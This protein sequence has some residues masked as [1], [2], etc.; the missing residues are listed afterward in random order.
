MW[1]SG[2]GLGLGVGRRG[3][4]LVRIRKMGFGG[5][6]GGG[7]GTGGGLSGWFVV[8]VMVDLGVMIVVLGRGARL[9]GRRGGCLLLG[10]RWILGG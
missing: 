3:I 2:I 1:G 6:L 4:L 8:V 5:L 9:C 7:G 10:R